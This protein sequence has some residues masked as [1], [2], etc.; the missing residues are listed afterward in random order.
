ME[1]TDASGTPA[2][3]AA[4]A[5]SVASA[6]SAG[7]AS[8]A[9]TAGAAG[10]PVVADN[11]AKSRYELHV[12]GELAGFITYRLTGEVID[13]LHTEVAPKFQGAGLAGRMAKDTLDDAR[14]RHLAVL[15]TCPFIRSWIR[16]HPG[17]ADLVPP[18]RRYGLGL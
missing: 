14:A 8:T 18:E 5:A 12:G 9:G 17:Y 10:T 7:A 1:P 13:L 4:D 16:R 6:A 11:A 2:A 3:P 15:P